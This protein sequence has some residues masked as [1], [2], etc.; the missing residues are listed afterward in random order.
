MKPQN[1]RTKSNPSAPRKRFSIQKLE[2]RIA[3]HCKGRHRY[4]EDCYTSW[5]CYK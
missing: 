5:K 4:Y 3:P 2:A 1:D